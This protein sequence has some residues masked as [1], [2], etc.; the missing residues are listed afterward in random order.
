VSK[1]KCSGF[2]RTACIKL[3]CLSSFLPTYINQKPDVHIIDILKNRLLSHKIIHLLLRPVGSC[4]SGKISNIIYYFTVCFTAVLKP[5]SEYTASII[6][7]LL[8][9]DFEG[10]WKEAVVIYSKYSPGIFLGRMR[11]T[12][13]NLMQDIWCTEHRVCYF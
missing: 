13:I 4:R 5:I 3:L 9:N 11:N 6:R 1:V 8:N 10:I 12:T 7:R 2:C